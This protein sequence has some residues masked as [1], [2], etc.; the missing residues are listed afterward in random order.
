MLKVLLIMI[1]SIVISALESSLV[2]RWLLS[3]DYSEQ[4]SPFAPVEN[5][6]TG[7]AVSGI[8]LATINTSVMYW[9][10]F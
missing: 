2:Y 10:I 4:H 5:A 7:A 3:A 8:I 9:I 1:V 6:L